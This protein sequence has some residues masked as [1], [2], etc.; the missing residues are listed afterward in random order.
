[1]G[2]SLL[3]KA[4]CQSTSTMPDTPHSR[5][6]SLPHWISTGF[7]KSQAIK[8]G[9]PPVGNGPFLVSRSSVHHLFRWKSFSAAWKRSTMPRVGSPA[10]LTK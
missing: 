5:A 9:P 7:E 6:G 3:A 1:M 4:E 10:L 8:N 2:A